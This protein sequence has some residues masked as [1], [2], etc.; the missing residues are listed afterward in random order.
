MNRNIIT[1]FVTFLIGFVT[2]I[3][4][5]FSFLT[6]LEQ[7]EREADELRI[8]Q[9]ISADINY[10]IMEIKALFLE[11]PLVST[12]IHSLKFNQ[13]KLDEK[14]KEISELIFILKNGGVYHK[15]IP[16]N[17]V[18]RNKYE[19]KYNYSPSFISFEA[20]DLEPKIALLKKKEQ[21]LS[22]ILSDYIREKSD[23]SLYKL[24]IRVTVFIKK[25]NSI[26]NRMIENSNRMF[27]ETQYQLSNLE[28]EMKRDSS[29]YRAWEFILIFVLVVIGIAGGYIVFRELSNLNRQLREKLY[30]DQLTDVFSRVKLEEIKATENSFL[31][32]IDIDSF[33]DIN[34]L[35]GIEIILN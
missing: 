11:L 35:Y 28:S 30:K 24:R 19:V 9:M 2:F 14:L 4:L 13:D 12:N 16:L 20:I 31:M 22:S 1:L 27:Y 6:L 34:E 18:S 7:K 25:L 29:K 3:V 17:L 23:K 26:F 8:K 15:V 5:H 21:E 32:L 10:K 33:S